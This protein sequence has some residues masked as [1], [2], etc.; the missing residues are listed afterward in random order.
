MTFSLLAPQR[1][2]SQGSPAPSPPKQL[3]IEEQHRQA[4]LNAERERQTL[5]AE[6]KA[7]REVLLTGDRDSKLY[8]ARK[9]GDRRKEL[10]QT[11]LAIV[12]GTNAVSEKFPAIDVLGYYR[13]A[14]A[15]SILASHLEWDAAA[16]KDGTTPPPIEV[17][18]IFAPVS[19]ALQEI[20]LP[21]IA[22]LLQRIVE[23]DDIGIL[24]RCV[25]ICNR[26]EGHDVT[27]FRLQGLLSK[28][29]DAKKKARIESALAALE[30]DE[31]EQQEIR[32]RIEE[33]RKNNK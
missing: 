19:S 7:L 18:K 6:K 12:E 1:V 21:A 23:T 11:L 3:S 27:Q 10:I 31:K 13:A 25:S 5:E 9:V 16:P 22:P 8:A 26:I 17:D 32:R 2:W 4:F 29:T 20:G 30:K 24:Q 15:A 33:I 28:E 14:E